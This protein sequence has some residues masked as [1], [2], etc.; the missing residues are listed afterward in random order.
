[1]RLLIISLP[2][3]GG[4]PASPLPAGRQGAGRPGGVKQEGGN[5]G[6]LGY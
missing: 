1:M 6:I 5:H 2:C 4:K 3:V